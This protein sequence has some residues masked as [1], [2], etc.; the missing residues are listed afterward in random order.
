MNPRLLAEW[1]DLVRIYPAIEH[2]E[3]PER[4][5]LDLELDS[6]LFSAQKTRVA[7]LIPLGYA[8]TGPDGFL[9]SAGLL[10]NGGLPA[11]DGAGA[12]MPG[13]LLVSFHMFDVSGQPTWHATADPRRG[14]NMISY[15]ASMEHFLAR[16]CN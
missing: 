6:A 1:S 11:S 16:G 3:S 5:E 15:L 10:M 14:D 12:G 2:R 9:V 4:I 13:W 8:A 7:V